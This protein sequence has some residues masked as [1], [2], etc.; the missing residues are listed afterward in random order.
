MVVGRI[1]AKVAADDATLGKLITCTRA[2]N[3]ITKGQ[4]RER[5]D[6]E[7]RRGRGGG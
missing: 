5:G 4:E 1:H 2:V 3:K 7:E 6:E